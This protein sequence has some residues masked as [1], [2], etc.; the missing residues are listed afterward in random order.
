MLGHPTDRSLHGRHLGQPKRSPETDVL[1]Q[2]ERHQVSLLA[3]YQES[4]ESDCEAEGHDDAVVD[5]PAE[6]GCDPEGGRL[7]EDVEWETHRHVR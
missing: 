4:S 5:V 6:D 3:G 1:G 2:H 7:R